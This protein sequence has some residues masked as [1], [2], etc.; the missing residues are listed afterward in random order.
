M[1]DTPPIIFDRATYRV[2]RK[3]AAKAQGGTFLADT[4][5]SAITERIA[6]VNCR[7]ESALNLGSRQTTFK[8]LAGLAKKWTQ[9]SPATS[10]GEPGAFVVT[11][12]EALPFSEQ[13]FDLIVSVLSLHTVNDLPGALRQICRLLKPNGLFMAAMFGG[14]TLTELRQSFAKAETEIRYG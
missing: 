4:A 6:A 9:A 10:C 5:V 14:N 11:D 2:R 7:F 13:S 12:E 8:E 3:R 1:T